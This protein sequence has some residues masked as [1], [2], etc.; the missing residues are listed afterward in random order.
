MVTHTDPV[1]IRGP[2][3]LKG[4]AA[5]LLLERTDARF[6]SNVRDELASPLRLS[7]LRKTIFEPGSGTAKVFQPVHRTSYVALIELVCDVPGS[8]RLDPAKIDS[9]GL[10]IRRVSRQIRG[11]ASDVYE[12]WMQSEDGAASWMA[13][14]G[15]LSS[16]RV[17]KDADPDAA[18]RHR[19]STGDAE[20]DRRVA[21]LRPRAGDLSE[22]VSE[23]FVMPARVSAA[24]RA[25]LLFGLMPTTSLENNPAPPL[26]PLDDDDVF[27]PSYPLFLQAVASNLRLGL[28]FAG[29]RVARQT[30]PNAD[31]TEY[32]SFVEQMVIQYDLLGE[33]DAAA[34]LRSRLDQILLPFPDS[35]SPPTKP[36]GQHLEEAARVLVLGPSEGASSFR[37]PGAWVH[38]NETQERLILD[39]IKDT[40]RQRL[41]AMRRQESRFDAP[42]DRFRARAFVRV[43]HADGCP[44]SLHWTEETVA[45]E[46]APWYETGPA[47]MPVVQ[48][49][50]P[51]GPG[52]LARF[53]P[54]VAFAVPSTIADVIRSNSPDQLIKGEGKRGTSVGIAWLCG[55]NIPLITLCAFMV[56][57]IFLS[58]FQIIFWWLAFIKICIPIP[59]RQ[60]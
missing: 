37:M 16:S 39:A 12:G 21:A 4:G 1:L 43:R 51:F 34:L 25:T 42:G 52:A 18:R 57:S 19:P 14:G 23:L 56:L 38:P 10:V 30:T 60:P 53:K 58:L 36:M 31:L 32:V 13:L 26:A 20:L 29:R 35:D 3:F 46:I 6:M 9:A 59:K 55:F 5:P 15:P 40:V 49:P 24:T 2:K 8:P 27:N 54:N 33:T 45:F 17:D 22:S 44:P 48:L 47:P 28:P 11:G 50:D 41:D 7:E